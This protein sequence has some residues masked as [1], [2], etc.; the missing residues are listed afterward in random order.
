MALLA[1]G[2]LREW[3]TRAE[4]ARARRAWALK[5]HPDKGGCAATFVAG[6]EAWSRLLAHF[7]VH[8]AT[9]AV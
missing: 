1:W 8:W 7:D 5:A 6:D 9:S 4:A 2:G 3:P